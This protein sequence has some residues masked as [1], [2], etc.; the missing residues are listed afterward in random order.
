MW[1]DRASLKACLIRYALIGW[2]TYVP[3]ACRNTLVAVPMDYGPYLW[4]WPH[5]FMARMQAAGS[6]VILWGHTTARGFPA[7]LIRLIYGGKCP[8]GLMVTSGPIKLR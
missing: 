3:A 7:G 4:G 1:Y 6:Q 8:P 5:R 2:A